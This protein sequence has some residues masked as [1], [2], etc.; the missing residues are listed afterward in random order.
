VALIALLLAVVLAA[1]VVALIRLVYQLTTQSGRIL[2]RLEALEE[3]LAPLLFD[4]RAY[5]IEPYISTLPA[6]TPV[7]D[8][9][10]HDLNGDARRLSEWRGGR[11]L[12]V[13][14]DPACTF[15]QRLLPALAALTLDVV[16]GRPVPVVVSRG[17]RDA[18]RA[19]LDEVGLPPSAVLLDEDS[20]AAAAFRVDGTPMSYLVDQDGIVASDVA[21]GVQATLILAGEIAAITDATDSDQPMGV[22]QTPSSLESTV[23]VR[24]G[25]PVGTAAPVFRL[26][27]LG[28]G[29]L[30]LLEYR[31]RDVV[32]VFSDP[33]CAP[34]DALAP[35]LEAVQHERGVPPLLII[36]RGDPEANRAKVAELG[37]TIPV[38]LQ[39][40]W[41]VSRQYGMFAT[42]IAFHID[43]WGII[44]RDV[45]VGDEE[46]IR[47]IDGARTSEAR[48]Q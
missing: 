10:L 11:S 38:A 46:I 5:G 47:L 22:E 27:R 48:S 45:A 33:D 21:V 36:G 34:C 17:S 7:P 25:L 13:F 40:H 20:R 19:W 44:A 31:G 9:R 6:G 41:E 12:L 42:P 23:T 32:V 24:G 37:L 35:H 39:R 3:V 8:L 2:L 15:S 26:P 28:G 16:P 43:E 29:E 1:I 4:E 14:V 18:N 30:S